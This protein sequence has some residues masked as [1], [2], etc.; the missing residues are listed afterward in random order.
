MAS[1]PSPFFVTLRPNAGHGLLILEA[2]PP[3]LW[4]FDTIE[5]HGLPWRGFAITFIGHTTLGRTPLDE[6]SARRTDIYLTTHNT[7]TDTH[8]PGG[9]PTNN[10]S[11]RA[12]AHPRL[13]P[14]GKRDRLQ[15]LIRR[16][17][18]SH[19]VNFNHLANLNSVT[20]HWICI[21][22][23][24]ESNVTILTIL[25]YIRYKPRTSNVT[26]IYKIP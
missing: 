21:Y 25:K 11:K 20:G 18:L 12:A 17:S 2:T 15:V 24:I 26:A 9:I 3:F 7:Q 14:R 16:F 5:G 1:P 13:R 6:W 10:S 8:A 19:Q 22:L 4:R 23:V